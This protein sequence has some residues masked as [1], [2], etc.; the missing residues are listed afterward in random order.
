MARRKMYGGETKMKGH[1]MPKKRKKAK[2]MKMRSHGDNA[3]RMED[4]L[5]DTEI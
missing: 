2:K 3:R 1:D 4:A 5:G